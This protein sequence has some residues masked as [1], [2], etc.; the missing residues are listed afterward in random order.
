MK[1]GNQS[2]HMLQ[3]NSTSQKQFDRIAIILSE[4]WLDKQDILVTMHISSRTL[5]RWRTNKKYLIAKSLVKY[6]TG[7]ETW[8]HCY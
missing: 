7:R 1:P 6:I 8:K 5:Q 4:T 3:R 2:N